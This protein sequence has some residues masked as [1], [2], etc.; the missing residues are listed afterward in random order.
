MGKELNKLS[1]KENQL[2]E[3]EFKPPDFVPGKRM[4]QTCYGAFRR[5][6]KW[7]KR[8]QMPFVIFWRYH[9]WHLEEEKDYQPEPGDHL[10]IR[11]GQIKMNTVIDVNFNFGSDTPPNKD[12]D[13]YSKTLKTYHRKLWSKTLP[14]GTEFILKEKGYL[15]HKSHLGEFY[16][17]SDAITHSYKNTKSISRIVDKVPEIAE[18][19]FDQGCRIAAYTIFPSKQINGKMSINQAR[20]INARIKDRFD[21]TLECIRLFYEGK[22]SPLT[23]VLNR[24]ESFF[25]L[26]SNFKSYVEFFL[27]QDLVSENFSSVKFHLPFDGFTGSPLPNSVDEY[28]EY[29]RNTENFLKSRSQRMLSEVIESP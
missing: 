18:N 15:Y 16:L 12:P 26:F 9:S 14:N 5:A 24:Y 2:R 22:A 29:A 6:R 27:F 3:S 13:V 1:A 19:L 17:G 28:L 21:L 4:A 11:I 8:G 25:D 23:D 7:I 20:G 10:I